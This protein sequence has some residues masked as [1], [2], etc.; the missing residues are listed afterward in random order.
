LAYRFSQVPGSKPPTNPKDRALWE[1][2]ES[3]PVRTARRAANMTRMQ[4]ASMISVDVQTVGHWES[5]ITQV[6]GMERLMRL[7]AVL[8]MPVQKFMGDYLAWWQKRPDHAPSHA[9]NVR[10]ARMMRERRAASRRR[11]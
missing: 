2:R 10:R 11:A 5:G 1:W 7:A 4:V 6:S 9:R 3:S 8:K